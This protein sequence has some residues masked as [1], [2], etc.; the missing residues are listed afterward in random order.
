MSPFNHDILECLVICNRCNAHAKVTVTIDA[1]EPMLAPVPVPT[2][3][4]K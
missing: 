1:D 4:K 2:A 3:P